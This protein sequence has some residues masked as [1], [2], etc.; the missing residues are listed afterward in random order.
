MLAEGSEYMQPS[1]SGLQE[2]HDAG[3]SPFFVCR[4]QTSDSVS[5]LLFPDA[6]KRFSCD[7]L[8]LYAKASIFYSVHRP[9]GETNIYEDLG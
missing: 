7:M 1:R 5:V 9:F 8:V 2:L 6:I 3:I 4:N